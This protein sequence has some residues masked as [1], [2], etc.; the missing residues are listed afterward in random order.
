MSEKNEAARKTAEEL[1]ASHG[2]KWYGYDGENLVSY[3]VSMGEPE[4]LRELMCIYKENGRDPIG[5]L[6]ATDADGISGMSHALK[7]EALWPVLTEFG[8]DVYVPD[9][10]QEPPDP[11]SDIYEVYQREV[12]I[13]LW[14]KRVAVQDVAMLAHAL[15]KGQFRD[16]PDG[17]P[18][19]V[20]PR[21]VYDML[22]D[23][24]RYCE[25]DN[26]VTLCVAWGHDLL[27]DAMPRTE[28]RREE[29]AR[30]IVKAGGKWGE[31]VLAGIREVSLLLPDGI[32]DDEYDRRKKEYME[33]IADSAPL[34]ILAV[35][36]ADRLCNTLD[37]AK[38]SKGRARRY[39]E[40]GRCLFRRLDQMPRP[41]LIRATLSRVESAIAGDD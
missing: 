32:S 39:L 38:A 2:F 41:E 10:L 11:C 15:H 24:W 23:E 31:E 9:L 8:V 12:E 36:M 28:E 33:G 14:A 37:F 27:E 30:R 17:R 1:V 4:V 6:Y 22:H 26:V 29:V 7:N 34:H 19:I 20:H 18:Y 5:E 40:K 16:P 3:A 25:M 13:G 35:K 21:A